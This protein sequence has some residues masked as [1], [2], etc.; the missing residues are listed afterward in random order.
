MIATLAHATEVRQ[1]D[2]RWRPKVGDRLRDLRD[3]RDKGWLVTPLIVTGAN[4]Y[5]VTCVLDRGDGTTGGLVGRWHD[6]VEPL[7]EIP[8]NAAELGAA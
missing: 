3:L 4:E 5:M 7:I 6:E 2:G 8:A 1:A